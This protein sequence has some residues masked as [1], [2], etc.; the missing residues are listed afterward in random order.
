MPARCVWPGCDL[1]LLGCTRRQNLHSICV[2]PYLG[3]RDLAFLVCVCCEDSHRSSQVSQ[4]WKW[5]EHTGNHLSG[6]NRSELSRLLFF[7]SFLSIGHWRVNVILALITL[8]EGMLTQGR[9]H[10]YQDIL[11]RY[12]LILLMC[13]KQRHRN[14]RINIYL[15]QCLIYFQRFCLFYLCSC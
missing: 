9:R 1:S 13:H 15:H 3:S 7:F 4:V 10:N 5:I 12:Y 6:C 11:L 8:L 14:V 2:F